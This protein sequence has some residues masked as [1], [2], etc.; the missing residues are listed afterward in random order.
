MIADGKT[1]LAT[2]SRKCAIQI[3][4]QVV[5]VLDADG[6]T[7]NIGRRPCS[8][9]LFRRQLPVRGGGRMDDQRPRIAEVCDVAEDF[10]RVHQFYASVIAA[11]DPNR[12]QSTST[13]RADRFHPVRIGR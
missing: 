6:Y 13:F 12:E 8:F 5:R 3:I 10:Q 1:A 9:L 11:L 2:S 7:D 4:D